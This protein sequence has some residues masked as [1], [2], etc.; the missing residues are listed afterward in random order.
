[1]KIIFDKTLNNAKLE[2]Y[3]LNTKIKMSIRL[4]AQRVIIV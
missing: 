1:M 3:F 2:N 4:F